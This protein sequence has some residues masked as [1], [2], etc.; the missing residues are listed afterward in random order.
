MC[1]SY[2][3]RI[4]G[5][6]ENCRRCSCQEDVSSDGT[7]L[8]VGFNVRFH[9]FFVRRGDESEHVYVPSFKGDPAFQHCH[10]FMQIRQPAF[11]APNSFLQMM[12]HYNELYLN[13]FNTSLIKEENVCKGQTPNHAEL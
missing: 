13:K 3:K 8:S 9:L 7:A 6:S 5:L 2:L 11:L 12:C 10:I 1:L 4:L